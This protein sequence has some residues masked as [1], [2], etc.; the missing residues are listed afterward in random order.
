MDKNKKLGGYRHIPDLPDWL[1]SLSIE[2]LRKNTEKKAREHRWKAILEAAADNPTLLSEIDRV[3]MV[4]L[5]MR[6]DKK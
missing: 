1:K 4:Y 6:V 2:D 5:L 3:E